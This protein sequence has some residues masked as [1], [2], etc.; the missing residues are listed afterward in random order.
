MPDRNRHEEE[1]KIRVPKQLKSWVRSVAHAR[2]TSESAVV[3]EALVEYQE[4]HGRLAEDERPA[5]AGKP[6]TKPV[7]YHIKRKQ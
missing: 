4:K 2:L 7:R 6:P 5:K 3:R 1:I